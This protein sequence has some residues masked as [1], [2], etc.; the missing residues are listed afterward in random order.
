MQDV[1]GTAVITGGANGIGLALARAFGAEGMSVVLGDIEPA[2]LSAAVAELTA[3]GVTATGVEVDVRSPEDMV[4]LRDAAL[5]ATGSVD[6][7]CLN[8]VWHRAAGWSTPR[9]TRGDG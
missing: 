2:T 7:V 4:R 3:A 9:S 5:D 6:V 8:V 1:K